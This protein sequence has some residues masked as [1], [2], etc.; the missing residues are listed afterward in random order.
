[1]A[2]SRYLIGKGVD[3]ETITVSTSVVGLSSM[4]YPGRGKVLITIASQPI[5]LR[6]DGGNPTSTVGH[7]F[8][9]GTT[10][11][12]DGQDNL[13]NI[14]FIRDTTATGDATVSVTY[15]EKSAL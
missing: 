6:Y 10:I 12:I 11:N 14:K 8:D 9:A 2:V 1:M 13:Q 15:E 7:Y 3:F 5:R 4:K